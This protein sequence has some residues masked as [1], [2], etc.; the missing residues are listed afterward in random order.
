M[1]IATDRKSR[2][3]KG[4]AMPSW[5]AACAAA[6]VAMLGLAAA[7]S[8]Q[9]QPSAGKGKEIGFATA[10]LSKEAYGRVVAPFFA[11]HCAGCHNAKKSEGELDLAALDPDMKASTSGARWAMLAE[12]LAT[13]EMPPQGRPRPD[14]QSLHAVSAWIKAEMKRAGKHFSRRE[15]YANGNRVN[16]D[17]S[18][19]PAFS[20]TFDTPAAVRRLSPEVYAALLKDVKDAGRVTGVRYALAAVF[21]LPQAIFSGRW[22]GRTMTLRGHERPATCAAFS[23]D[24][25]TIVS[26]SADDSIRLWD[27]ATG[28]MFR[29]LRGG[30][31]GVTSLA[32][33]EDGQHL[34]AGHWNGTLKVWDLPT[35]RELR[36]LRGHSENVT[37]VAYSRD[38]KRLASGSGDDTLRI[39]NE[40]AGKELRSL[41]HGNE[42]D[43]TAVAFSPDGKRIASGDGENTII[44]WDA[45]RGEELLTLSGHTGA[46]ACI[47]FSP[48]GKRLVSA[49]GDRSLK[50]WDAENGRELMTLQGHQDDVATVAFRPDGRR[51]ASGS[52]DGTVRLWD[53]QTGRELAE[54]RS[55]GGSEVSAVAFSPD[56]R[57]LVAAAGVVLQVWE[58]GR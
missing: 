15:A 48:D 10:Q 54:L 46:I 57:R 11:K 2:A 21:L 22:V 56:G 17:Q 53:A 25:K 58:L 43:I 31:K 4:L 6:G 51:L 24:G 18:F 52:A 23:P 50:V 16:H 35:G 45:E 34:V 37:A 29:T 36:T 41:D 49:S 14:E 7:G 13:R 19:A 42:Y 3:G 12:K 20:A 40:E 55:P 47:A 1:P 30:G 28:Q 39:W 5:F 9:E 27:A 33:R 38:G 44:I 26:G 8:A 32:I